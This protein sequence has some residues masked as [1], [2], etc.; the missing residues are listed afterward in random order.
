MDSLRLLALALAALAAAETVARADEPVRPSGECIDQDLADK[1][2]FKRNRRGRVPRDFVKA[3]R[4]ELSL[5]GGYF[6][7]DLFSATYILGGSYTY[8]MTEETAIEGGFFLTHSNADIV[9]AVEDGRA[10]TL[11]DDFASATFASALL[12]WYPLHGKLQLGGAIIHFDIHLD[13]GAGVVNSPTSR[14]VIGIGGLGFKFYGGKAFAWRIDI[15]DNVY[16]QELL[17]EGYIVNDLQITTGVSLF[18]PL[19]F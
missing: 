3:Q 13:A 5:V 12:L 15:R 19:G 7:S 17:D 9:R 11:K 16:R 10:T 8:H 4:H 18:L 2:A 14:G 6:V 1:L